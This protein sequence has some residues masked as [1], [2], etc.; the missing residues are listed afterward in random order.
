MQLRHGTFFHAQR[1]GVRRQ[2]LKLKNCAAQMN[3]Q[4][5]PWI[6]RESGLAFPENKMVNNP[7]IPKQVY[8]PKIRICKPNQ[9]EIHKRIRW[10]KAL[11]MVQSQRIK[12]HLFHNATLRHCLARRSCS[13]GALYHATPSLPRPTDALKVAPPQMLGTQ[14]QQKNNTSKQTRRWKKVGKKW[15]SLGSYFHLTQFMPMSTR[16]GTMWTWSTWWEASSFAGQCNDPTKQLELSIRVR[17]LPVS[18]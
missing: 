15:I 13:L 17:P 5:S 2:F 7:T 3:P 14:M 18:Q 6:F 1:C 9:L 8:P 16:L 4:R 12:V 11:R 10:I